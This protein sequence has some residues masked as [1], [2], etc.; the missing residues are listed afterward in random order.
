V[1][2]NRVKNTFYQVRQGRTWFRNYKSLSSSSSSSSPSP[3]R[4]RIVVFLTPIF[5]MILNF[6]NYTQFSKS[7]PNCSKLYLILKIVFLFKNVIIF[8]KL[9]VFCKIIYIYIYFFLILIL[10]FKITLNLSIYALCSNYA[11][12]FLYLCILSQLVSELFSSCLTPFL[13]H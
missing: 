7:I 10:N 6:Q 9:Y 11:Q 13:L 1:L 8:L 5:K 4:F 12:F 3:T 2:G